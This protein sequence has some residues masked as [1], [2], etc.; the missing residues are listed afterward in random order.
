MGTGKPEA[1]AP[2][3]LRRARESDAAAIRGIIRKA[4]INPLGIDWRRF[5]LAEVDG[6]IVGTGQIKPHGDGTRELSSI[7]VI[8]EFQRQ[9]IAAQIITALIAGQ[10]G[11]LYLT[12]Q[13]RMEHYYDRFGFRKIA[14]DEMTAYFRRLMRFMGVIVGIGRRFTPTLP[15]L[16]VMR[17]D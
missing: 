10:T 14:R 11:T 12:C 5:L 15:A 4:G 16:I 17:R 7:A 1:H 3:S 9:G 13:D 6:H 2:V 8:P